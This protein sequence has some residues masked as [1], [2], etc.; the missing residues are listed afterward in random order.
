[1]GKSISLFEFN[2]VFSRIKIIKQQPIPQYMSSNI[3]IKPISNVNFDDFL[4]LVNKLAEY[5][6]LE[7][8]DGAAKE[9]LRNDGL[10]VGNKYEAYLAFIDDKP[11]GYLIYFF[12]Y[13]SFLALPTLYIEDIFILFEHRRAGIGQ[14]LFDLCIRTA[15]DRGCGR[16]EWCVLTWNQPAIK[17]YEKN[18]AQRLDWYFYRYEKEKIDSYLK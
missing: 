11:V 2:Y 12:T 7:P 17:F 5:E 15:K 9:R 1:M 14:Q 16:M 3:I 8:P 4:F 18:K 6:K 13:S 10:G